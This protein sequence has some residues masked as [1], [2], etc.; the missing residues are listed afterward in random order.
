MPY[1]SFHTENIMTINVQY[2]VGYARF[3]LEQFPLCPRTTLTI[4]NYY[5]ILLNKRFTLLSFGVLN[6]V[7]Q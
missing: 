7:L 4:K 2:V 3:T 5:Y 6:I 1:V